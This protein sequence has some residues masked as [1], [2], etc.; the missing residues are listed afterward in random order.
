MRVDQRQ[1]ALARVAPPHRVAGR[2]S[3][4]TAPAGAGDGRPWAAA[5]SRRGTGRDVPRMRAGEPDTLD[6]V[7]VVHRLEQAGEIAA[8]V[9]RRLVVV[10]DLAEQLHF[11]SAVRR[12]LADLRQDVGLR[13]HAL[14]AAR[15]RDDAEAAELVAAFDDRDVRLHRVVPPRHPER[16]RHIVVRVEIEQRRTAAFARPAPTS[17]GSRRMAWVPMTTSA[18]P[19]ERLKM[20]RAFLLRHAA[21]DGDNRVVPAVLSAELPQLAKARVELLLGALANAAGVDDDDVGVG[22]LGSR[23]RSRPARGARPSARS[24]GRSSGS[25]TF[26]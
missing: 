4:R 17:I 13:P 11:A 6:A 18:T 16:K 3:S 26:R 25:R 12:G 5:A 14:V 9:V 23:P 15:V 19:G 7:D 1:V 2:A 20:R 21:G 22:G 24:R 10:H 8:R